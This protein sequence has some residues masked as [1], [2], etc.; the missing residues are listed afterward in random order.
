MNEAKSSAYIQIKLG[1]NVISIPA[2]SIK[3]W[4]GNILNLLRIDPTEESGK[5]EIDY[6]AL[7]KK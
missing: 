2:D 1:R 3:N 7:L 5:I 6:I 4:D